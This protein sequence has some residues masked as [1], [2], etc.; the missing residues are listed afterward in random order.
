MPPDG[1]GY[2]K[3]TGL[4]SLL[5]VADV[6][7]SLQDLEYEFYKGIVEGTIS[8]GG[9]AGA[10]SLPVNRY[11]Q[12]TPDANGNTGALTE[13]R[14]YGV[15]VPL[16]TSKLSAIGIKVNT[17]SDTG[18]IRL[19]VRPYDPATGQGG[20]A[21]VDTTVDSTTTGN[22]EATFT[23]VDLAAGFWLFTYQAQDFG[24]TAPVLQGGDISNIYGQ[25][26]QI[27]VN[28][29]TFPGFAAGHGPVIGYDTAATG[30]LPATWVNEASTNQSLAVIWVKGSA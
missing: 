13:Y 20:A 16:G 7:Q 23:A 25:I 5:G 19:G 15:L 22:K 26:S 8:L 27:A 24:V 9:G 12:L 14:E 6:G 2:F 21:V 4:L 18:V 29:A 28:L 11:F 30:A 3:R 17:A 1:I 10:P